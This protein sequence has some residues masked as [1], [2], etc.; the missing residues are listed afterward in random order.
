MCLPNFAGKIL[1]L[2]NSQAYKPTYLFLLFL[3]LSIILLVNLD[4]SPIY[5]LDEAKNAQCAREMLL[6][7]DWVVPT[8]NGELRTDKPALHYFFMMFAYKLF[9]VNAFAARFFSAIFGICTVLVTYVYTKRF[10]NGFTAFCIALV[11]AMS[12]HFLFEFRLS[13]PDPY[14]IF[15]ITLGLLSAFTWLEEDNKR[16]L[17][18]A[19]CS[20]ALATVAKGPVA[21]ALP[22]ASLLVWVI[23]QKKWKTVFTWHLLPAFILLCVITLPWYVAVYKATNGAWTKGFFIEHNLNRFS[24]PQEG[25]GGFFLLPLLF[26]VVGLL[27]FMAFA[28]EA[29]KKTKPL[30]QNKLVRFSA[31]VFGVFVVFFSASSTKL[32]NYPMPCYPFAATVLGYFLSQLLDGQLGSKRY[33]LYI[34]L[35]ILTAI[36][37]AGFFA[38]NAEIEMQDVKGAAL[39]LL[40]APIAFLLLLFLWKKSWNNAVIAIGVGFSLLNILALHYV[41][42]ILY[43]QNPM[44]KTIDVVKKAPRVIAYRSY[45][46]AYNFYLN[47]QVYL[48]P[49]LDSIKLALKEHPDAIIISRKE[50]LDSLNTLDVKVIATHHDVFELP[51]TIILTSN[52]K[53]E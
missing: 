35:T 53:T 24:D 26:V 46:P 29:V 27:P 14:L 10:T 12:P 43:R 8:F 40:I 7:H 18:I 47:Q 1:L 45:N 37:V 52:A 42:P 3:L 22:G 4:A 41:Y 36:P 44:S 5:I 21:L 25:H 30:L 20:F 15:F 33:P 23:L 16:Q 51:T 34:L 11:L 31:I 49:T 19:A 17:Y 50:Y 32:P 9:G 39:F 28:G 48:Y 13:V 38:A 6:R 2:L